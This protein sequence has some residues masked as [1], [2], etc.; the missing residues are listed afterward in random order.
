M[1]DTV[2]QTVSAA[3]RRT[4]PRPRASSNKKDGVSIEIHD[5][6]E[7]SLPIHRKEF[8]AAPPFD[9]ERLVRYMAWGV[10]FQFYGKK[11]RVLTAAVGFLM[12]P[13]QLAWFSYLSDAFP[14]GEH[15]KTLA[16][17]WRVLFDQLIFSP[18]GLALFFVFMAVAEGGGSK[19]VRKKFDG[20]FASALKSGYVLWP[21]VQIINFW[22]VPLHF[23]LV[24][25]C[26]FTRSPKWLLMYLSP[27]HLP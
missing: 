13:I 15:N 27:S 2:A 10:Q 6:G 12:A 5:L 11:D 19:A 26:T 14:I 17:V 7:K 1:A 16:V 3:R 23:Q 22:L 20:V 24:S 18:I 25:L 4:A 21:A 8:L 9:T